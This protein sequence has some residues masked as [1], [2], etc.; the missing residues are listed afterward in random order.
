MFLPPPDRD[1]HTLGCINDWHCRL[2]RIGESKRF[3]RRLFQCSLGYVADNSLPA[4]TH[5]HVL[6]RD[7]L[8]AASPVTLE[9]LRPAVILHMGDL[10]AGGA[11]VERHGATRSSIRS[12]LARWMTML[13]VSGNL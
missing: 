2:P 8:L 11:H 3:I 12:I 1:R 10:D 6:D 13:T 5:R 4:L 9:C 7:L